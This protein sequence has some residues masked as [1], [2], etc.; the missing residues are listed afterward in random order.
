MSHI[1]G[2]WITTLSRSMEVE[3][4]YVQYVPSSGASRLCAQCFNNKTIPATWLFIHYYYVIYLPLQLRK[5][6]TSALFTI[7]LVILNLPR[8]AYVG[9]NFSKNSRA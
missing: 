3:R 5:A 7:I 9:R 1:P 4:A 6:S 2:P 8:R